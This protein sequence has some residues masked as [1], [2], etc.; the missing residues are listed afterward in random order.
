VNWS[1]NRWR[2]LLYWLIAP[3]ICLALYR[4]GLAGWFRAD[5]F[6][7]LQFHRDTLLATLFSPEALGTFRPLSERLFFTAGWRMFGLNAWPFHVVVFTT[8]FANLA[9]VS[10]IGH[11]L[12]GSRAAGLWAAIFW[13]VNSGLAVTLSWVS[14]YNQVLCGFFLLLALYSSLRGWRG[15]EWSAFLLGF[16]A[17]ETILVYPVLSG[18]R[19]L[20]AALPMAAVSAAFVALHTW[21]SPVPR[22]GPYVPYWGSSFHTFATYWSWSLGSVYLRA[23]GAIAAVALLTAGIV[24]FAIF[25]RK[26]AGFCLLW[27]VVT[28]APVLAFRDH[29]MEYY[30]YLPVIGICWIGGA[31]VARYRAAAAFAALYLLITVPQAWIDSRWNYDLTMRLR[32]MM[33]TVAHAPRDKAILLTGVDDELDRN[34]VA[35]RPFVLVGRNDVYT[36][37]PPG[38]VTHAIDAGELRV[39]D[40][41]G[42][43]VTAAQP[44]ATSLPST[45]DIGAPFT[46]Y[47]LGPG[48]YF[49]EGDHRW[50][51][52]RASLT[53]AAGRTLHL[54]GYNPIAGMPVTVRV[55]GVEL[56][57]ATVA[58]VGWFDLSFPV[59]L[60][61]SGRMQVEIEA[62]L[63]VTLAGRELGLSF[64]VIE[65]SLH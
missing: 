7:W 64:G 65:V 62:G 29:V 5:D 18:V 25:D 12:T 2:D 42:R 24:W 52:R 49:D 54:H 30:L 15:L 1:V 55:N 36:T 22:S 58:N 59:P 32:Q 28:L 56:P 19:K 45:V 53:M 50:M 23:P 60:G 43:D 3:A 17:Q 46:A 9:L 14:A 11:R 26:L 27:F 35:A 6:S 34:G 10:V 41:Q 21:I 13:T 8:H 61:I 38:V 37:L 48:W 39:I 4:R 20:R 33:E 31:A 51:G 16:G 63:T 44:R 47:L 57:A 40:V